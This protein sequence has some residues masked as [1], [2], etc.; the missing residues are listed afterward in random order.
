[1]LDPNPLHKTDH[2]RTL[3]PPQ[4]PQRRR[5][6][7]L[8]AVSAGAAGRDAVAALECLAAL[9]AA[10]L[11]P[12]AQLAGSTAARGIT[13]ALVVRLAQP[14][15]TLEAILGPGRYRTAVRGRH[16]LIWYWRTHL[17]LTFP[18][19][20]RAFGRD[21]S[22]AQYAVRRFA[23][24]ITEGKRWALDY[25]TRLEAPHAVVGPTPTTTYGGA[26]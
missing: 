11:A 7:A 2:A 23:A 24:A 22:T 5:R 9:P 20:G 17:G 14:G 3:T 13:A 26:P 4:P 16:A 15:L 12:L 21:H 25:K 19:I 10:D 1:M 18:E 6:R 8:A